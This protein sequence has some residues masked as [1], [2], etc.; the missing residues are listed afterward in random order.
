MTNKTFTLVGQST[1]PNGATKVRFAN[2]TI[3][4]RTATLVRAGHLDI[5]FVEL[6]NAMTKDEARAYWTAL[7]ATGAAA[8]A[9]V[10]PVA[11]VVEVAEVAEV[12]EVAAVAEVQATV[13]L[14]AAEKLAA[15]RAKDAA[16]KR[17]ARALARAA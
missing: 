11:E 12:S 4:F 17:E 6:P 9:E 1:I 3:K 16:R 13:A 10:V 5:E 2:G 8:L 7:L 15:K 14:T